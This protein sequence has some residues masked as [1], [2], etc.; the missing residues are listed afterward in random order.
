MAKALDMVELYRPFLESLDFDV[1]GIVVTGSQSAG[2][3][4]VLESITGIPFPRADNMCTRNPCVV[5]LERDNSLKAPKVGP[6]GRLFLQ[7]RA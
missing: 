5:S 4:S 1:P 2:K 7:A 6:P 3:S